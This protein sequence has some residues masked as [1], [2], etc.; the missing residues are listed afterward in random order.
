LVFSQLC[1]VLDER[2]DIG[3]ACDTKMGQKKP[4]GVARVWNIEK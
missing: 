3:L 1:Q 2:A 4:A